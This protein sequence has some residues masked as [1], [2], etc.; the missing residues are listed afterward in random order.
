M[1]Q[2]VSLALTLCLSD[3]RVLYWSLEH[4]NFDSYQAKVGDMEWGQ[5]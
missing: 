4:V 3:V 5:W 1:L 2:A